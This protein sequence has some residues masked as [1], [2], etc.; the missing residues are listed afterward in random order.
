[1]ISHIHLYS[2]I[3]GQFTKLLYQDLSKNI[4][5]NHRFLTKN[6]FDHQIIQKQFGTIKIIFIS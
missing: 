5:G 4:S 2:Q 6:T 3:L 1:M